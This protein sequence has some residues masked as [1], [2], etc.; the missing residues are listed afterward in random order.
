[1][2]GEPV[3][4]LPR[5]ISPLHAPRPVVAASVHSSAAAQR[6]ARTTRASL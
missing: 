3:E 1:V 4:P 6:G 2:S 5:W